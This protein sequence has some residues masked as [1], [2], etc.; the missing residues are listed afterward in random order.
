M[1]CATGLG[2][3]I[4]FVAG[5]EK[6]DVSR[7]RGRMGECRENRGF[8]QRGRVWFVQKCGHVGLGPFL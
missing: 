2:V 4:V 8:F 7:T 5:K 3:G 6:V 1:G